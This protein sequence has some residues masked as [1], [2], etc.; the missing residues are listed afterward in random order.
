MGCLC[1]CSVWSV[2]PCPRPGEVD[3]YTVDLTSVF[4]IMHLPQPALPSTAHSTAVAAIITVAI[5]EL[6]F[7]ILF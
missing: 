5:A 2:G 1:S 6:T 7:F 4:T 3:F